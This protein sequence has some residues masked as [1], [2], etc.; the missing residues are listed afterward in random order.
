M[1]SARRFA[2]AG[3][4][5]PAPAVLRAGFVIILRGRL[6]GLSFGARPGRRR[7]ISMSG[8]ES[9]RRPPAPYG[10]RP[11]AALDPDAFAGRDLGRYAR[12]RGEQGLVVRGLGRRG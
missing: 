1:M 12:E 10:R 3:G 7:I 9:R 11:P 4:R 6:R 2:A 8:K 5:A